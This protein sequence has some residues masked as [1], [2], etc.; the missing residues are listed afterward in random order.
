MTLL[1]WHDVLLKFIII[2]LFQK[3]QI[4][5]FGVKK[6]FLQ[7]LVDILLLGSGS[8]ALLKTIKAS[9]NLINLT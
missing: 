2:S 3:F 8:Q 9:Q 6:F 7:F 1:F 5:G 4:W